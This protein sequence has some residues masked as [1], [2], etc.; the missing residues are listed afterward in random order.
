MQLG[1]NVL[2]VHIDFILKIN[3]FAITARIEASKEIVII[4]E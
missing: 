3:N 1:C 2:C 4:A